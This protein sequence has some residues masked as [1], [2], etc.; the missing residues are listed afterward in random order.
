DEVRRRV[1]E[2][3][4]SR[5]PVYHER[6]DNVV[7]ILLAKDLLRFETEAAPWTNLLQPP[8]FV[9]ESKQ[10]VELLREMREA[11]THIALTVDEYG[12]IAGIVTLEDLL[13]LIV[14]DIEDE[15]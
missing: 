4:Y 2:L 7:G 9:P 8:L 3:G 14:G 11:R 13:E 6:D 5:Y 12:N 15:F 10:V 1:A